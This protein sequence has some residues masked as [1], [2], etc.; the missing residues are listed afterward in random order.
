MISKTPKYSHINDR[1]E[2][3]I[4]SAYAGYLNDVL[5]S[6]RDTFFNEGK[7]L[8][9]LHAYMGYIN[10]SLASR[11]DLKKHIKTVDHHF[12]NFD[13]T[14]TVMTTIITLTDGRIIKLDS[15]DDNSRITTKCKDYDHVSMYDLTHYIGSIIG[16]N[17]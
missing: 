14:Q 3:R 7:G 16:D 6:D 15:R 5:T 2:V 1:T 10:Y 13:D 8:V 9:L 12:T 4:S 11:V 17:Q